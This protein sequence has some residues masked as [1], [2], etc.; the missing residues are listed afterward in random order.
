VWHGL[1]LTWPCRPPIT[2][3]FAA[4]VS[5]LF[6]LVAEPIPGLSATTRPTTTTSAAFARRVVKIF[7]FD[8]KH[9]GNLEDLPM[10]WDKVTLSGFPHYVNGK[11]DDAVGNPKPSFK[12]Q[13]NGGNIGYV[14]SERLIPAF[15]GSDHKILACVKT[16]NLRHARGYLQAFYMDRFGKLLPETIVYSAL[17]APADPGDPEWQTV[18]MELPYTNSEGRF[19]GIGIFLVQ[20][21]Q[22]PRLFSSPVK[23]Y[24]KDIDAALWVD[25]ITV[26][27]LPK[28]RFGLVKNT[29]L[30]NSSEDMVIAAAV[31][32]SKIDD[33]SARIILDDLASGRART[34]EHPVAVLP[35]LEAI[36]RGQAPDPRLVTHNMGHLQPGLYKVSLQVLSDSEIIIDKNVKIAVLQPKKTVTEISDFG[37]DISELPIGQPRIIADFAEKLKPAW[38]VLPIWRKDLIVSRTSAEPSPADQMILAINHKG[39]SIIGALMDV[40]EELVERTNIINPN[41]WDFFAG[42][43]QWWLPELSIVLS[44]HADRIDHWVFG[45]PSDGWHAPDSRINGV[46]KN[47]KKEFTQFQGQFTLITSWPSLVANPKDTPGDGFFMQIPPELVPGSFKDYFKPWQQVR[48]NLWVVL[49]GQDLNEYQLQPAMV[50]FVNRFIQAKC[51]RVRLMA[52]RDLWTTSSPI[53]PGGYEPNAYFVAYSNLVDRLGGLDYLGKMQIDA[54][55]SGL[56]FCS[57]E[58]AVL[59][60]ADGRKMDYQGIVCLGEQPRA[61]DLWGRELPIRTGLKGLEIPYR[62]IV[63]IDGIDSEL[64]K[65]V[66][67]IQFDPSTISSKFGT[68]QA[69]LLFKNTFSQ[70]ISGM[71]R[72]QGPAFWQ[73]DPSGTRFALPAGKEFTLP[74]K[75]RY[76]GNESVGQKSINLKFELE[77]RKP[78]TLNLTLPLY[79]GACDLDMR[80][81][82]FLRGEELVVCQE[83]LNNGTTWTDLIAFMICPDKPRMERQIRRLGPGQTAVKEYSLGPWKQMFGKTI[84][85]GFRE[86]RGNR[87]V[88][89]V[90]TLE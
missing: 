70:G 71:V 47:L 62:P 58:R 13:L 27:R 61:Y 57:S 74:T 83:V 30:Y 21:D 7:D 36:L 73:F 79:L 18:T 15:P 59:V 38:I 10:N 33:L 31:A 43:S 24:R 60:L 49:G 37:L 90:I 45:K 86:V 78:I 77:A 87:L 1:V 56:L 82:W 68:H 6:L 48:E 44:R 80:V 17:I 50:D 54:E 28:A 51:N 88:N 76:P 22:L 23:S 55:R 39:I 26:L 75:I 20:Q 81:L 65:F 53:A 16:Q 14:F 84:R 4:V 41:I 5:I 40:P 34:I 3:M 35:P 46:L 89:E 11:I 64:A 32:D 69:K 19:I 8:E 29:T 66:A 67:A 2:Q 52:T 63:F 9:L 85:V 12:F 72:M 42:K 25:Q